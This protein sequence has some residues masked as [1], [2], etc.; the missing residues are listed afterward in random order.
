MISP[1][2]NA[3]HH[4]FSQLQNNQVDEDF[5]SFGYGAHSGKGGELKKRRDFRLMSPQL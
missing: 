5:N 1:D 4:P 3:Y 2:G